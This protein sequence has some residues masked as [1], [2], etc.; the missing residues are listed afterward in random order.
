VPDDVNAPQ[1]DGW[2]SALAESF[3]KA[4]AAEP[5]GIVADAPPIGET[6]ESAPAEASPTAALEMNPAASSSRKRNPQSRTSRSPPL[7]PL[8]RVLRARERR[9]AP[10]FLP[11]P[12][13]PLPLTNLR[14]RGS[15]PY[16]R[17]GRPCRPKYR[18]KSI[19]GSGRSPRRC[20]RARRPP[21]A[22]ERGR[23]RCG[24]TRRRSGQREGIH[25]S[26]SERCSRRRTRSPTGI[27]SRRRRSSPASPCSSGSLRRISIA[28]SWRSC[29]AG[30]LRSSSRRSSRTRASIS[31]C[32]RC[33]N[34]KPR[35]RG[36]RFPIRGS[37]GTRILRGRVR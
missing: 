18:P 35:R 12:R 15:R 7:L 24:L 20:R 34:G 19:A 1:E 32:K 23:R 2:R 27:R 22:Q 25:S 16:G 37:S 29:R 31:S 28:P 5:A 10:R 36:S 3:D 30:R 9:L 21:R 13:P 33:S 26:T 8:N 14:N 17:S 4:A 6:P 11:P